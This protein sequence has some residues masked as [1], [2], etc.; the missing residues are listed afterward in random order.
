VKHVHLYW[1]K[2]LKRLPRSE[3]HL[4]E[5]DLKR[6]SM[7]ICSGL[8][9]WFLEM[10]PTCS[11]LFNWFLELAPTCSRLFNCF[12]EMVPT[13]SG[14]FNWFLET[15]PTCSE[16]FNY[17]IW[18]WCP[19]VLDCLISFWNWCPSVL[20]CL[21]GFWKWCPPVLDCLTIVSGIGAHL[22]WNQILICR[23]VRQSWW[24]I[25]ILLRLVR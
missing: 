6:V 4:S 13:C 18:K 5:P 20:D 16:L 10:V 14:L 12:L 23:S 25:S 21:T 8:F 24:A 3:G 11:G 7:P 17:S 2:N 22:F 1:N 15:V 19:P 9:N